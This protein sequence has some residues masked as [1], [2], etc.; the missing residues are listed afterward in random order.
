[1]AEST[2]FSEFL[3]QRPGTALPQHAGTANRILLQEKQNVLMDIERL[4]GQGIQFSKVWTL[5]DSLEDMSYEVRRH[6]LHVEETNNIAVMRDGMR[7]ICTGVEMLNGRMRILDLDGW[8]ADVCADMSKYDAALGKLHRKYWRRS[9]STSPEMELA[10]TLL[11]SMGMYHFKRK[12]TSRIFPPAA[13]TRPPP[14]RPR[15]RRPASA[16]DAQSDSSSEDVPP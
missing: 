7:M 1:V 6:M 2:S 10:T 15:R 12:I 14:H 5:D 9:H 4:R 13:H 16:R 3:K 11:M 8:A